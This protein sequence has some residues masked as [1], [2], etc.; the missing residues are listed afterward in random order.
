VQARSHKGVK[1][2]IKKKTE[3]SK[4][5]LPVAAKLNELSAS[6]DSVY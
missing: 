2:L 4:K 5:M 6:Y 1:K 3:I